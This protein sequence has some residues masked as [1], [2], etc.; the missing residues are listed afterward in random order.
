MGKV[1]DFLLSNNWEEYQ[2]IQLYKKV[3]KQIEEISPSEKKKFL[4]KIK[5]K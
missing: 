5:G 2:R 1:L 3:G 4:R